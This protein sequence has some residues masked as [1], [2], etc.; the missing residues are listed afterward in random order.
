[1]WVCAPGATEEL[2]T[3][4]AKYAS[5][6]PKRGGSARIQARGGEMIKLS[7]GKWKR[8]ARYGA[9]SATICSIL[10]LG[11]L[12]FPSLF[13]QDISG[14]LVG[15]VEDSTGAVVVGAKVTA[16]NDDTGIE[17]T[18]KTGADGTYTFGSL[19]IG[20]YRIS[21]DSAGFQRYEST[22]NPIVAEQTA[23]LIITLV[24]GAET[25]HIEVTGTATQVDTV[26]PTIQATLGENQLEALPVIGRDARVN[27]ELTQ[28]GA[29]ISENANNGE[30]VRVNGSR[31]V[32]NNYQIDGTEANEYLTGNA[33]VLPAV[34]NLQEFSDITSTAGAEYGTSAGSQVSAVIKSGTNQL[35]GMV[36]DYLQNSAWNAN[37]WEGNRAGIEKPSGTQKWYGGNLGGPVFIPHLYDGRAK[38]FWF[39][40]FEYTNPAQQY[41]QQ[42]RILTNAERTGDFSNSSFGVPMINGVPTPQL[43]PSQFSP[44]AQAFLAD[45]T[46]MPT[47]SDP[48]G[49]YSWLGSETDTVKATVIKLDHQFSEKHRAFVSMFRRIDNQIRDP[50]LGI[51]FGAPTPPDEGTSAY[52]H[53]VSTYA[54]NDTY[55]FNSH[56]LNNFILGITQLNAGPIRQTVN[57]NL[58]WQTL[59]SAVVPDGGVPLTEVGIFIN[60]WGSNGTSIWGNYNNPNPTHEI[61]ISDNFTWIKGRH[62]IKVGYYQRDFHE[63]TFQDFCAAGCYTFSSG[64]VGSTGNPFADFLLGAGASFE[65]ES[66]ENLT[67]H[68]PA[69]E[70]Y[71]HDQIKVAKR[72]TVTVGV[73]WAPFFG[74]QEVNGAIAAFRPGQQSQVFPNAPTGLVVAGDPGINDA[75]FPTKWL[76]FGPNL[77]FSYDLT[78]TGKMVLRGGFGT[79]YDYFNLSQAGN[80]GSIAPYG[81]TYAPAGV[82]VSVTDPYNGPAPFP[83][84]KPTAGSAA[85]KSYV[86]T[87][88]PIIDGYTKNFNAGT[89][90]QMNGTFEWQPKQSWLVRAGYVGTRG[91][92]LST[93]YDH[94][95]PVFIA[96]ASTNAN[97]QSRRPY[98]AF[99]SISL[100]DP[101]S[102][103]WYNSMQIAL[104]KRFAHGFALIANYTLSRDTDSGDSIGSYF[105]A[106]PYRDPYNPKLDYGLASFDHPQVFNFVYTWELPFFAHSSFLAREVLHGWTFGGT[107]SA[108]SGDPLT[109]TSPASFNDGSSN[110]AYA[111]YV[112][113]PVYG[114]RSTRN[115]AAN[116]WINP[117]AF[118]PANFTGTGCGVQ[119]LNAGVT[120]LDLGNTQ[121]DGYRGPGMLYNDMTLAKAFPIS[122]RFGSL[123][124]S[125][126]AQNVFNH[127]V[128][129]DPDTNVTDGGFGQITSTR[130]PGYLAPAFGRVIQMSL[131]YQF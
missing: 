115:S 60:G 42:L 117:A 4:A 13:A 58:N 82:A 15:R 86:F 120:H 118:C 93:S 19:H 99:Q 6:R 110:G 100:T 7:I 22:N 101:E 55:T 65:E 37:S 2:A 104:D 44:M 31:G 29:V 88:D 17:T 68:Y 48:N 79:S 70:A 21:A 14:K 28:P 128:L 50:L 57:Q 35:H 39:A 127:P 111:N 80:L 12:L 97:E 20:N 26:S 129:A 109:I 1:M 84:I 74:Y 131:H 36:W 63:H 43:N 62:T 41:L 24:P 69:H 40:S 67:W 83:Y 89:T 72:L 107:L 49:R 59:G 77:G 92:H 90:Y 51:Q 66:T 94:N 32:T 25:Q 76:N 113:G 47:T 71:V 30:T 3:L 5:V 75:S 114:D 23:T 106:G 34:E 91:V 96:G 85:A 9:I 53:S 11:C 81:Y 124:Y 103:S 8:A 54:F 130:H 102:N 95:A 121:R 126:T 98:T 46:L 125:L 52:Q 45:P 16:H 64:N 61:S 119:D 18:V 112:G 108:I 10:L 73:R 122:E 123:K 33:A 87:G 56:T 78:G 27:V 105:S 38:T 116:D